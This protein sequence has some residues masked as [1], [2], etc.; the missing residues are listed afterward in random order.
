MYRIMENVFRPVKQWIYSIAVFAG[1]AAGIALAV[2]LLVFLVRYRINPFRLKAAK[3]EALQIKFRPY[4]FLR[5]LLL[6]LLKGKDGVFREY[7]FTIFCGRQGAGKTI[8]MINY[9]NRMKEE[10]P[11]C[12]IV[13]NFWYSQADHQMKDWR[14][15][16]EIRN[17]DDGVIF[18]IDEIHSEYSSAAW[19]DFPESLLSEISQQRK[20][21]V[22]IV[23]TAQVFSRIAKPIR[24]QAF[25]VIQCATYF[26]RLTRTVE[27]DANDY[28]ICVHNLFK[29]KE[30]CKSLRKLTFVQTDKLRSCY[31]TYEKIERMQKVEFLVRSER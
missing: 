26:N 4:N 2:F 21:K 22:K 1:S 14:D 15:L 19:K 28:S 6:D 27:Y 20:Q 8:S 7:G 11:N 17:G 10:H 12:I 16:M 3:L 30:K 9:L 5:Y 25:S 31:D 29:L 23:A 24:E 18:A 13:T